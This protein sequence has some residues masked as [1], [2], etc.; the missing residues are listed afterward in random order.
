DG[1]QAFLLQEPKLE[2]GYQ[3]SVELPVA[4]VLREQIFQ[5]WARAEG[6]EKPLELEELLQFSLQQEL[7]SLGF[8]EWSSSGRS[9][10]P[11]DS[12]FTLHAAGEYLG[13]ANKALQSLQSS[14][15]K[16]GRPSGRSKKRRREEPMDL[17]SAGIVQALEGLTPE[18]LCSKLGLADLKEGFEIDGTQ[19][20]TLQWRISRQEGIFLRGRYVKL[21]RRLPQSPWL[22]E[23]ERKGEGS[24]EE[25]LAQPVAKHL[26]ASEVR[27]HAEGREDIDVRML[28]AGRP[29]VLEVRNA[30]RVAVDV[31]ELQAAINAAGS[32]VEV[33]ELRRS[34]C[35]MAADGTGV[36]VA[37]WLE[38]ST[39]TVA[40]YHL[41]AS[42]KLW[43]QFPRLRESIDRS[44]RF[45]LRAEELFAD[46]KAASAAQWSKVLETLKEPLKTSKELIDQRLEA[47]WQRLLRLARQPSS[48]EATL[49]VVETCN[50]LDS[51]GLNRSRL[52]APVRQSLKELT[53]DVKRG[54]AVKGAVQVLAG[55][56]QF[57]SATAPGTSH[58]TRSSSAPQCDDDGDVVAAWEAASA[59][60]EDTPTTPSTAASS[61]PLPTPLPMKSSQVRQAMAK[62]PLLIET[63]SIFEDLLPLDM[64]PSPDRSADETIRRARAW[65]SS[66]GL[67]PSAAPSAAA[68]APREVGSKRAGVCAA[69]G[70]SKKDAPAAVE[71]VSAAPE[72][73]HRCRSAGSASVAP[74]ARRWSESKLQP[75]GS[76]LRQRTP[77]SSSLTRTPRA[78]SSTRT[79][80]ASSS[81][82][83]PRASTGSSARQMSWAAEVRK[84]EALSDRLKAKAAADGTGQVPCPEAVRT[85]QRRARKAQK[86][87]A[88]EATQELQLRLHQGQLVALKTAELFRERD[89][90]RAHR[91]ERSAQRS[92]Q[93][94]LQRS[95][96]SCRGRSVSPD[97][98]PRF[99]VPA[100][101]PCPRRSDSEG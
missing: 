61:P 46:Q 55:L 21:S 92:R 85:A 91:Q 80:R 64:P 11:G 51:L 88:E 35:A 67:A 22:I 6:L 71:S 27:F 40:A 72:A 5:C 57:I 31:A 49:A 18:E 66:R 23:G 42:E 44:E 3:L 7:G 32:R 29:F 52:G 26:G 90:Q 17:N 48:Q 101:E 89:A 94:S 50:L 37:S 62:E 45:L 81:T 86:K 70:M 65:L 98:T 97:L 87:Q 38:R 76:W 4:L 54:H 34:S 13:T 12:V 2:G 60:Q 56:L 24:V 63:T 33:G 36:V 19:S 53:D 25:D 8:A 84:H 16:G 83:T 1:F 99:L 15:E 95:E 47:L 74:K 58:T 41:V 75:P 68:S 30:R 77:S 100:P 69:R 39:A 14:Q 73:R 82:R 43:R 28:G 96:G 78:S 59:V 20:A 10:E 93:G 79:P 9:E